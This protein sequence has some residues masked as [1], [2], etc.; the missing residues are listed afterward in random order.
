MLKDVE[1]SGP[2]FVA[3]EH[4]SLSLYEQKREFLF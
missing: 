3:H 2:T 4:L 1:R